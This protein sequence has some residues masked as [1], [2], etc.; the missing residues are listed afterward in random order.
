MQ[1]FKNGKFINLTTKIKIQGTEFERV[2]IKDRAARHFGG[3]TERIIQYVVSTFD[4][5]TQFYCRE[6]KS[7]LPFYQV[8]SMPAGTPWA[9]PANFP[10]Y[11]DT[12]FRLFP[13]ERAIEV[14]H[15]G[16]RRQREFEKFSTE[17]KIRLD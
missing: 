6:K 3:D 13:P 4:N 15:V 8:A 1:D 16:P 17:M 2:F 9:N 10:N 5:R 12:C 7:Y 11:R 14:F